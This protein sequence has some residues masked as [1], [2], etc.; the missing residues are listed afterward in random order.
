MIARGVRAACAAVGV[1]VLA[2]LAY[3][4]RKLAPGAAGEEEDG[5][6]DDARRDAIERLRGRAKGF[7]AID[8]RD[9]TDDDDDAT[10]GAHAH[11]D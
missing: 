3:E 6:R 1:A 8:A 10:R 4:T 9:A 5:A 2:W 7:D 11:G